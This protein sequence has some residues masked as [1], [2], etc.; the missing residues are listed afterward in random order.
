MSGKWKINVKC[1]NACHNIHFKECGNKHFLRNTKN[2]NNK[3]KNNNPCPNKDKI[4]FLLKTC[5]YYLM[6]H[7]NVFRLLDIFRYYLLYIY[8]I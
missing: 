1:Q 6:S 2:I 8:I 3:Q 5:I 7:L 4:C